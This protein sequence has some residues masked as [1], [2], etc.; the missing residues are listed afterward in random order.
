M[1]T[2]P[3]Q[4]SLHV[5]CV[6]ARYVAFA[7]SAPASFFTT[8]IYSFS[9]NIL[10]CFFVKLFSKPFPSH[11]AASLFRDAFECTQVCGVECAWSARAGTSSHRLL[12][13]VTTK[14]SASMCTSYPPPPTQF[15]HSHKAQLDGHTRESG[16]RNSVLL[17]QYLRSMAMVVVLSH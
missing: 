11:V 15:C 5:L 1:I 13:S 12:L 8:I 9:T 17:C 10:T 16:K 2:C 7:H 3:F 6:Q 14:Y 4:S